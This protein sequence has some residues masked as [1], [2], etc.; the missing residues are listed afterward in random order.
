MIKQNNK[1]TLSL[2]LLAT[3]SNLFATDLNQNS[4]PPISLTIN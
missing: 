4:T 2:I 3:S 1:V